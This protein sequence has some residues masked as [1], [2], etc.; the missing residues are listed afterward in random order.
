[1]KINRKNIIIAV[2]VIFFLIGIIPKIARY[3]TTSLNAKET[4]YVAF[5]EKL[6]I[7]DGADSLELSGELKPFLQTEIFSRINGLVKD[8]Y[9]QLGEKV[10]KGQLLAEIDTPDLDAEAASAKSTLIS[11]QKR[12]MEAKYQLD[13]ASR[14]YERYRNSSQD[15]A[16][17][18]QELEAKYNSFKTSEMAYEG[19][20]ADVEKAR[21]DLNRLTALQS[22]KRVTSPFDGVIS[23][24]NIDAGANVV[25]GGSSTSTSLFE[26]QQIDKFRAAIFVPQSYVRFIKDGQD[27]DVYI[28]ENP[29]LKVKGKISQISGKLD[30]V[31]RTMEVVLVIP[32]DNKSGLYSGLYVK[33]NLNL[34]GKQKFLTVNPSCLTTLA[35][36]DQYVAEVKPDSA[37]HFIK[38]KQ[39]RDLGD[40]IEILEGLKGDELLITNITDEL[41]EGQKVKFKEVN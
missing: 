21:E 37:I 29:S 8:R 5:V 33:T 27:V 4:Q 2:V 15:G 26:V 18:A 41:E 12:L 10:K 35:G 14:T 34:Q 20:K 22:Y 17:S 9:V 31:S 28:P 32:N 6:Q 13:Y 16:I 19:A 11:A 36:P 1:M 7:S 3:I 38:V 24:Y 39:G 40:R 25:A 23:K 30:S